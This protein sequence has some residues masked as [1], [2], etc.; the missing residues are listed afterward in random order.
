MQYT[1]I[2]YQG[3]TPLPNTD[4]WASLPAAEQQAIYADY[5]ALNKAVGVT[6]GLPLGRAEQATTVRVVDGVPITTAGP[7]AEPVGG[8]LVLEADDVDSA[9]AL[10]ARIPA[11]RHGG[12]I[13]IRPVE[14]YW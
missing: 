7:Y 8:Y 9:V 4:A 2:I 12:A 6:P 5:A 14:T 11:A 1:L 3:T 13:E 10:A